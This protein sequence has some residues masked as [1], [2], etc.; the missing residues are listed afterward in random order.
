MTT[1]HDSTIETNGQDRLTQR[2]ALYVLALDESMT[3]RI[4]RR[5]VPD[6]RHTANGYYK[7]TLADIIQAIDPTPFPFDEPWTGYADFMDVLEELDADHIVGRVIDNQ[8]IGLT[9]LGEQQATHLWEVATDYQVAAIREAVDA[10]VE[11]E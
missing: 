4:A 10:A 11:E 7:S 2:R 3:E 9:E 1:T 5:E 8:R 6:W